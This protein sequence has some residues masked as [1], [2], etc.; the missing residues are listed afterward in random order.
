MLV[1]VLADHARRKP[2]DRR[3]HPGAPKP[4]S[5]SLQPTMPSSVMILTKW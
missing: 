1:G 5:Y 4:S 3:G 2:L